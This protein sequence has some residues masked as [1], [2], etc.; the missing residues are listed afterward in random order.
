LRPIIFFAG[1]F[2]DFFAAFFFVAIS[3]TSTKRVVI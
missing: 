1:F 2:A 3:G